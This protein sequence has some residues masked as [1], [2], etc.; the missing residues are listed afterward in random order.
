MI[1][2]LYRELILDHYRNPRGAAEV[3]APTASAEGQNPLCGDECSVALDLADATVRAVQFRG[4]GC[5]I[6]VASGSMMAEEI[7]GRTLDEVAA[8]AAA[9]RDLLQGR[10]VPEGVDLGDLE[11]LEGVSKFPVRVK[12]ALLP[13]TTLDEALGRRLAGGGATGNGN[14]VNDGGAK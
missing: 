1:D 3:V 10:G 4:R 13:W 14:G 5:S 9:V 6:S 7:E 8:L 12:C 11:V 2:D